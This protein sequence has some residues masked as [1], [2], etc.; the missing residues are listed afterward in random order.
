MKKVKVLPPDPLPYRRPEVKLRFPINPCRGGTM[1]K[2]LLDWGKSVLN[3]GT[4]WGAGALAAVI[5]G[6]SV[7][8]GNDL[9]DAVLGLVAIVRTIYVSKEARP[10]KS[11]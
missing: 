8:T 3:D 6:T 4:T 10:P 1:L 7:S 9:V 2:R 11:E 5:L